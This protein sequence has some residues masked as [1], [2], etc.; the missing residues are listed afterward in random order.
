V[1]LQAQTTHSLYPA[2]GD[3]AI[4]RG[5]VAADTNAVHVFYKTIRVK[6]IRG[7]NDTTIVF[8]GPVTFEGEVS[9]I[10]GES[11]SQEQIA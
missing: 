1:S 7:V 2:K 3:S 5:R 6:I 11:V 4:H 10:S 9:G 8:P